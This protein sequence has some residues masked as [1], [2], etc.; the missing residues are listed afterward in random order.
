MAALRLRTQPAAESQDL[1]SDAGSSEVAWLKGELFEYASVRCSNAAQQLFGTLVQ[2]TSSPSLPW[3]YDGS[4]CPGRKIA[5]CSEVR[6][7]NFNI[8]AI[9]QS[10]DA[11]NVANS[12]HRITRK[13]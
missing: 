11:Y 9:V 3:L 1:E 4:P 8:S 2:I 7:L 13:L 5:G 10:L 12:Q 6:I